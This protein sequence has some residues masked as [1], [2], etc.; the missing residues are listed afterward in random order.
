MINFWDIHNERAKHAELSF[1][2]QAMISTRMVAHTS[3]KVRGVTMEYLETDKK[4]LNIYF[5]CESEL[6]EYEQA[7]LEEAETDVISDL[8]QSFDT[9]HFQVIV[10]PLTQKSITKNVKNWGWVFKRLE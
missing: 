2:T 3:Y 6:D 10:I 5:Y 9:F 8:G 1:Y 7:A 4:Q